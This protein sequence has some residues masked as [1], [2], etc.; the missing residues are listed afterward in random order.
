MFGHIHSTK[1]KLY[2]LFNLHVQL[3][4]TISGI[5]L[6]S[7]DTGYSDGLKKANAV[8]EKAGA[9]PISYNTQDALFNWIG[10]GEKQGVCHMLV[11]EE[12][13]EWVKKDEK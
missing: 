12:R 13:L 4:D 7:H 10:P 3:D 6:T 1:E 9:L 2:G 11:N 8:L 5:Y